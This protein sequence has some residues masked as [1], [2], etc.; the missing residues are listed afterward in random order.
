MKPRRHCAAHKDCSVRHKLHVDTAAQTAWDDLML[1]AVGLAT[2]AKR[3]AAKTTAYAAHR[4]FV[5]GDQSVTASPVLHRHLSL[6]T[7][8]QQ[9]RLTDG[10]PGLVT[11]ATEAGDGLA[12]DA[13]NLLVG[14]I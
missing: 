14:W 1:A 7:A 13:D 8:E 5:E 4:T 2:P 11:L 3:A 6:L 10:T 12:D 9:Q